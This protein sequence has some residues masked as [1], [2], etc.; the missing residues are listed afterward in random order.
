MV[1]SVI[2]MLNVFLSDFQGVGKRFSCTAKEMKCKHDITLPDGEECVTL[3]GWLFDVIGVG[4]VQ[5]KGTGRICDN[6]AAGEAQPRTGH[7]PEDA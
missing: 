3:D 2:S 5:F 6:K 7:T 1:K 4:Q